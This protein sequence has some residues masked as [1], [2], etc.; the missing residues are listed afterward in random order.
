MKIYLLYLISF[1]PLLFKC[2]YNTFWNNCFHKKQEST[3]GVKNVKFKLQLFDNLYKIMCDFKWLFKKVVFEIIIFKNH[4]GLIKTD[5]TIISSKLLETSRKKIMV[6][7]YETF[8]DIHNFYIFLNDHSFC[9]F[10]FQ[11]MNT[12]EIGK[13]SVWVLFLSDNDCMFSLRYK[14]WVAGIWLTFPAIFEWPP[15]WMT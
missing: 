7:T 10:N 2:I 15:S 14:T 9:V 3:N 12:T 1:L 5:Y 13:R 6:R 4:T 8:N 11:N